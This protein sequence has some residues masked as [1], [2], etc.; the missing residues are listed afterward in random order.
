MNRKYMANLTDC[1]KRMQRYCK[2]TAKSRRLLCDF[3]HLRTISP[4]C[5]NRK[6]DGRLYPAWVAHNNDKVKSRWD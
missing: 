2:D 6:D 5:Y 3:F 1:T 4:I